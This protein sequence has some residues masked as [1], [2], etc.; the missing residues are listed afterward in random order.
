MSN[1][2]RAPVDVGCARR[3]R[4]GRLR[5]FLRHDEMTVR[6]AVAAAVHHKRVQAPRRDLQRRR[7]LRCDRFSFSVTEDVAP[8][9]PETVNTN[10]ALAPVIEYIALSPAVSYP[11]CYPSF[12]QPN[13][14]FTGL[15][16]P[17]FSTTAD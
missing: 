11:S 13:E 7:D 2:E 9:I 12:S 1:G 6:M 15:V 8:T 5:C 14:A 10:V 3:R 4:E 17:Q 16:N